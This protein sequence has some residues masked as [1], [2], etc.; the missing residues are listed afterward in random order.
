M[1]KNTKK[2]SRGFTL[3]EMIVSLGI[4]STVAI[5]AVGS[6]VRITSLNRQAQSLQ[7]AMNDINYTLE[8]ISREMRFGSDYSCINIDNFSGDDTGRNPGCSG[9]KGVIFKSAKTNPNN[10]SCRLIYAYWFIKEPDSY[11]I[12]KS[13]QQS[14]SEAIGAD[15]AV[16]LTDENNIKV[17]E[18]KINIKPALSGPYY[19]TFQIELKG[20]AGIKENERNDFNVRTMVSQRI[21]DETI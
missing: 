13:Q 1:I 2:L 8:S 6:L 16:R 11:S 17:E 14:C 10:P 4:F 7:S 15:T 3:L 21:A 12:R 20:Y 18:V 5:I 19:S 9:A